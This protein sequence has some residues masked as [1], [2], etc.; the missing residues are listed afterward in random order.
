MGNK[1]NKIKKYL[2]ES[3]KIKYRTIA[4]VNKKIETTETEKKSNT[5]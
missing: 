5:N 1:A 3:G 2:L 4:D